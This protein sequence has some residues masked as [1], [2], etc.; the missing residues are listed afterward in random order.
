M[1][2]KRFYF[3]IP[4]ANVIDYVDALSLL[5]AQAIAFADYSQFWNQIQWLNKDEPVDIKSRQCARLS[6]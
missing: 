5:D 3:S 2:T 1:T 6:S 4:E